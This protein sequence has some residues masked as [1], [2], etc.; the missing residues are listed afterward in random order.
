MVN[1]CFKT[2]EKEEKRGSAVKPLLKEDK[3]NFVFNLGAGLNIK[4]LMNI[5]DNLFTLPDYIP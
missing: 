1:F 5:L 2:E 3:K 4:E